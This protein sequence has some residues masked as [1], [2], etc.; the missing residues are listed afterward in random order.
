MFYFIKCANLIFFIIFYLTLKYQMYLSVSIS[1]YLSN[2][3]NEIW[4]ICDIK[5]N[6]CPRN[7]ITQSPQY[8]QRISLQL[9][10]CNLLQNVLKLN[11]NY[12][13]VL[14]SSYFQLHFVL[15]YITH[16]DTSFISSKM[17]SIYFSL[18]HNNCLCA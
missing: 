13:I 17:F 14:N 4:S 12:S 8:F 18:V 15:I 16:E 9:Q 10:T 5:Y 2:S 11:I 1:F 6:E 7:N 3:I